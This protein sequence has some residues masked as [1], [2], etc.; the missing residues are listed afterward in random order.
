MRAILD[1]RQGKD[2]D[3]FLVQGEGF[4]DESD[5]WEPRRNL[6]ANVRH[7]NELRCSDRTD[8]KRVCRC[9]VRCSCGSSRN[10]LRL[11]SG[12]GSGAQP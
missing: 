5:T 11:S 1:K 6:E 3:E 9:L 12:S 4:G 7:L 2:G 10:D 8:S